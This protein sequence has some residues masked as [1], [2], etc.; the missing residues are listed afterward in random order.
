MYETYVIA[1]HVLFN[2]V[3]LGNHSMVFH[4]SAFVN[5]FLRTV[6]KIVVCGRES[7]GVWRQLT[8]LSQDTVMTQDVLENSFTQ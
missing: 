1:K 5:D 3:A 7:A 4:K 8:Q 2:L 6:V